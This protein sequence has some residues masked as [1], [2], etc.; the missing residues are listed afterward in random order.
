MKRVASE[1]WRYEHLLRELSAELLAAGIA[2][3]E[4]DVSFEWFRSSFAEMG[5][6]LVFPNAAYFPDVPEDHWAEPAIHILR[7]AGVLYG[8]PDGKYRG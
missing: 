7:R 1:Y 6:E 3:E 2:Q 8:Y 5:V 4:I